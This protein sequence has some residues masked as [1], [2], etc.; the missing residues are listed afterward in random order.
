MTLEDSG[1]R[2]KAYHT[3]QTDRHNFDLFSKCFEYRFEI[4]S[5]LLGTM[6]HIPGITEIDGKIFQIDICSGNGLGMQATKGLLEGLMRKAV[7]IGV[8]FDERALR[9][10]DAN[11]PSTENIQTMFIRGFAQDLDELLKGKI[12]EAGVNLVTIL[13]GI[14]EVPP[15]DQQ[16]VISASASKLRP[17]GI[18]VMNSFFTS[19]AIRDNGMEWAFPT[20]RAAAEFG[21]EPKEEAAVLH[22]DP[23]EYT[24]ML[25]TAGLKPV[26]G[27]P[28]QVS[29]VNYTREARMGISYYPG[30]AEGVIKSYDF[31]G[32]PPSM[33]EF[34]PRLAYHYGASA[35]PLPRNGVSW[36]YKKAT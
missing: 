16:G 10:A 4:L 35:K 21:G 19:I 32:G 29:V 26:A 13:D 8:D 3:K 2:A 9:V 31:K 15:E 25:I 22:R 33:A 17:R 20:F 18:C 34:A 7:L 36:I 24:E 30:F 14:H 1:E 28:Y 6:P 12:P 11:T 23:D 27:G 5:I